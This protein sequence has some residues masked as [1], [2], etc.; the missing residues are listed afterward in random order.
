MQA[1][2]MHPQT[3]EPGSRHSHP[4]G[5]WAALWLGCVILLAIPALAGRLAPGVGMFLAVGLG[6]WIWLAFR[7]MSAERERDPRAVRTA[8]LAREEKTELKIAMGAR[9]MDVLPE[10]VMLLGRGGRIIA[11]NPAARRRF[12]TKL[13]GGLLS[14]VLRE[15]D[16]LG[17]VAACE[18]GGAPRLVRFM[19]LAPQEEHARA[20]VAPLVAEDDQIS[21]PAALVL[22]VIHD[23][24]ALRRAERLRL[25]FLANASHELRTPLTS[26]AGFIETLR[27]HAKDDPEAREYFLSIMDA[28]TARMR[29][30]ISDLL[31]LS[32]LELYEHVPPEGETDLV[33][34]A[35]DVAAGLA[36]LAD[37]A[38]VAI[39]LEAPPM[40]VVVA[41]ARDE[42]V[43]VAQNLTENA[44]KYSGE[45]G[46]V[47]MLVAASS[48]REAIER[49]TLRA[50]DG[51]SRFAILTPPLDTREYGWLS[52]AD[53]GPGIA[54]QHLPRLGERFFRVDAEAPQSKQG[55]GLG[56]AIAKHILSRHRGGLLVSSQEGAGAAFTMIAPKVAGR[57]EVKAAVEEGS[58]V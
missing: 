47:R 39:E 17:A 29:R 21:P 44:I 28:Q 15:P 38:K 30:L 13:E 27:G 10:P 49:E 52:V 54:R 36:P 14:I 48:S 57:S 22:L 42:L 9:I 43:Q 46:V 34:L 8:P 40:P 11:A 19:S 37:E 6:L 33:E 1:P 56:L 25:D 20:F 45:G 12:A 58:A 2:K 31:S 51:D 41:G 32:R 3:N 24:T 26:L 16:V 50:G 7:V 23:E 35:R 55:T 53:C 4:R 18:A 5:R